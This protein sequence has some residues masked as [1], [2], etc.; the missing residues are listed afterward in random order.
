MSDLHNRSEQFQNEIYPGYSKTC[1]ENSLYSDLYHL[2]VAD[3]L[4][5]YELFSKTKIIISQSL[6]P[7]GMLKEKAISLSG[8]HSLDYIS[9]HMSSIFYHFES[10]PSSNFYKYLEQIISHGINKYCENLS[11]TNAWS[12]SNELMA[13]GTLLARYDDTQNGKNLPVLAK[14]L[15][16]HKTFEKGLWHSS[17]NRHKSLINSAAATFHYLPMFLHLDTCV[18]GSEDYIKI[19]RKLYMGNGFFSAPDGYACIDYDVIYMIF[20]CITLHRDNLPYD[21]LNWTKLVIKTHMANLLKLQNKDGGFGEYGSGTSLPKA[22]FN[23]LNAYKLNRCFRSFE[24]NL[25]K[26][27]RQWGFPNNVT[28]SN[29]VKYCGAT[30]HESNIFATWFRLITI[31][32][33]EVILIMIDSPNDLERKDQYDRSPGLGYMPF[34]T[35]YSP[36]R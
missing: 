5:K 11:Y 16:K 1:P 6:N 32:L 31:E 7:N 14:F 8:E 9:L 35:R 23:T 26:I 20:Y 27:I 30:M 25:K 3:L 36:K 13:F 22:I 4:N 33:C 24:W 29:S 2:A 17:E 34:R 21:D 18:P 15:L 12:V 19:A 10:K 28:Y